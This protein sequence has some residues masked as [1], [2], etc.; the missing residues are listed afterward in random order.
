MSECDH[1][2]KYDQLLKLWKWNDYLKQVGAYK[3]H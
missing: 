1:D 3:V 2:N